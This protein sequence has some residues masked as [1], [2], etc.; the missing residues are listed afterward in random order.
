MQVGDVDTDP[1][2]AQLRWQ[3]FTSLAYGAKG[4]LYFCYNAEPC[5]RG[6][7][8]HERAPAG[9]NWHPGKTGHVLSKGRH[10]GQAL[11]INSVLKIFGK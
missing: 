2:E 11:R 10:Y 9:V 1:T 3:I 6:G 8:L 7:I 4:V 5:G